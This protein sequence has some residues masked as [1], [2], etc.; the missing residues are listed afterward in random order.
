MKLL[1]LRAKG[2]HVEFLL[3][4]FRRGIQ[5]KV[6]KNI[7][8]TVMSL[9]SVL[10]LTMDREGGGV[11]RFLCLYEFVCPGRA[12][13]HSRFHLSFAFIS[14]RGQFSAPLPSRG[15]FRHSLRFNS[16]NSQK[17]RT[18]WDRMNSECETPQE[19]GLRSRFLFSS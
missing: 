11:N 8:K 19:L 3:T 4:K 10:V 14:S 13:P 15:D 1:P 5:K 12:T 17:T 2:S 9:K 18:N 16:P 7:K 6:K